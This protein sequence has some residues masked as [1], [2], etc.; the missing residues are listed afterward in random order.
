[1]L[2]NSYTTWSDKL[3]VQRQR[4]AG[5]PCCAG[6]QSCQRGAEETK[7]SKRVGA[8]AVFK[9]HNWMNLEDM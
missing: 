3:I 1:M 7:G 6:G 2:F 8:E 9:C 4:D 5:R